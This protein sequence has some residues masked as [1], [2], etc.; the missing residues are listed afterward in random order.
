MQFVNVCICEYL[1]YVCFLK[2]HWGY[3]NVADEGWILGHGEKLIGWDFRD[4]CC[5]NTSDKCAQSHQ[6]GATV[7]L[8][9]TQL[10]KNVKE[11]SKLK[12]QKPKS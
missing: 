11:T 8:S 9:T 10:K 3:Q 6:G 7:D 1:L 4:G 2:N 5:G 12:T